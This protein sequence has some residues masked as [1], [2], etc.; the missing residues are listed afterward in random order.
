M[1]AL[2]E[3]A[4][5]APPPG[6]SGAGVREG[7][8]LAM[9]KAKNGFQGDRGALLRRVLPPDPHE[10]RLWLHRFKAAARNG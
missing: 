4:G 3:I 2:A 6:A 10:L 1:A 8:F 7:D 9:R 5:I